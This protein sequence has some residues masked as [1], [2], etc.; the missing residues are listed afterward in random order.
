MSET[1]PV[2]RRKFLAGATATAGA[3]SLAF[4]M[5]AKGQ[6]GPISMRWQST[7]PAKDI[8]HEYAGDFAKSDNQ[9]PAGQWTQRH[10]NAAD[11]RVK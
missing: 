2:S 3:A 4:P 11:E 6:A 5:I 7:W 8:F 1:K 10:W 9:R